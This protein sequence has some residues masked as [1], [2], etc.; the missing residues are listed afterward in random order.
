MHIANLCYTL[1]ILLQKSVFGT[2]LYG[3]DENAV[4]VQGP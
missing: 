1:Y 2:H 4:Y 3:T